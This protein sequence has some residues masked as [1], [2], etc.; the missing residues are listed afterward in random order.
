[1]SILTVEEAANVLRCDEDDPNLL[2]LLPL[3]D[4]YLKQA[5]GRDWTEDDPI[6]PEAKSP[7]R[8][9]LVQWMENPG[10]MAAASS[11]QATLSAGLL[12]TIFQLKMLALELAELEEEDESI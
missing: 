9:L 6:Y 5:T 7:A 11:G 8:M 4:S 2:A 3:V 1:M 12:A 10:M